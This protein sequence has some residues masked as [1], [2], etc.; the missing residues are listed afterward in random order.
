MNG[1]EMESRPGLVD[2]DEIMPTIY[3]RGWSSR[4]G[5]GCR[6]RSGLEIVEVIAKCIVVGSSSWLGGRSRS[7]GLVVVVKAEDVDG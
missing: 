4:L 2:S 7:S 6:G 5:G 1:R 3:R